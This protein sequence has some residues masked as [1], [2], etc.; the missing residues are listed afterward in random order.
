MADN[1][2]LTAVKIVLYRNGDENFQG[3]TT[4]VNPFRIRGID[5]LCDELQ[6]SANC[7]S[8]VRSI[9]SR[10]GRTRVTSVAQLQSGGE[11]VLVGRGRYKKCNYGNASNRKSKVPKFP[12]LDER[13]KNK[14]LVPGRMMEAYE[15]E[16]SGLRI[17]Q[18]YH[19]GDERNFPRKILLNRAMMNSMEQ[20]LSFIQNK[21]SFNTAVEG[22]YSLEGKRIDQPI[23]LVTFGTYVAVERGSKFKKAIYK[24]TNSY[25]FSQRSAP[26]GSLPS[27]LLKKSQ[28]LRSYPNSKNSHQEP[29]TSEDEGLGDYSRVTSTSLAYSSPRDVPSSPSESDHTKSRVEKQEVAIS[30]RKE[31]TRKLRTKSN[32]SIKTKQEPKRKEDPQAV[33]PE[34]QKN[35]VVTSQETKVISSLERKVTPTEDFYSLPSKAKPKVSRSKGQG[36]KAM[37]D[38]KH[39]KS[40]PKR[41]V[42]AF[43]DNEDA[44]SVDVFKASGLLRE[45]GKQVAET[46]NVVADIPIDALPAEEVTEELTQEITPEVREKI[47]DLVLNELNE[48]HPETADLDGVDE[49][50]D[51]DM[52]NKAFSEKDH[53]TTTRS[54]GKDRESSSASPTDFELSASENNEESID[55]NTGTP[56]HRKNESEDNRNDENNENRTR[57]NQSLDKREK[58]QKNIFGERQSANLNHESSEEE[59]GDMEGDEQIK[60]SSHDRIENGDKDKGNNENSGETD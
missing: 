7:K 46:G 26:V 34:T 25:T 51:N 42:Q 15:S 12:T 58:N 21:I 11:Y 30:Y 27:H 6:K 17:L 2:S 10:N 55:D 52:D 48:T 1:A 35:E 3:K 20:I 43:F 28:K 59:G 36:V 50:I 53:E 47:T 44:P 32:F 39:T 54:A 16:K 8:A 23:D 49:A 22:L 37:R 5:P 33:S 24:G 4:Y 18:I 31:Q 38:E 19:N 41:P 13:R 14:L 40:K 57:S 56:T 9:F 29:A 45:K 60:N